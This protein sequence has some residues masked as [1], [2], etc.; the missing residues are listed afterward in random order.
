M[1][2]KLAVQPPFRH[3]WTSVSIEGED[4]DALMNILVSRLAARD[5]EI[6]V[7]V[8]GEFI[9]FEDFELINGEADDGTDA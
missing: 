2:V 8:D 1:S 7:E 4:E 5:Y 6:E 3:D 9:P